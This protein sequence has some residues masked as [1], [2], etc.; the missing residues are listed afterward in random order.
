MKKELERLSQAKPKKDATGTKRK[1]GASGR[2]S[3]ER[4]STPTLAAGK[5]RG[6][7]PET[8]KV[9]HVCLNFH[10]GN[11]HSTHELLI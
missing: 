6:R 3:E 2:G 10:P 9:C 1:P 7:D 5:K 11:H 8:E 4:H